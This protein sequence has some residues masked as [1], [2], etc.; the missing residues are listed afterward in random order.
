[1]V[2]LEKKKKLEKVLPILQEPKNLKNKGV[3]L[4]KPV[5]RQELVRYIKNSR[6][7]L[8]QGSINETFCMSVA[9]A[10]VLGIPTVVKNLGCLAERVSNQRIQRLCL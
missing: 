4:N 9:E 2:I 1:M 5:K 8:Y 6:L 3:I 10:Q 7:F